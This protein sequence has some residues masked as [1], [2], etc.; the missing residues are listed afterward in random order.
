MDIPV[1]ETGR[2]A[3]SAAR[4]LA[5]LDTE[6]KNRALEIMAKAII[7]SSSFIQGE[8]GKDLEAGRKNGLT[9]AML[10]RLRLDAKGVEGMA[11]GIRD[12]IALP[13]PVGRVYDEIVRP[14]G[15]KVHK[16]RIPIGVFGIIYESRPNVTADASALCIKSGNAVILRGGSEAFNSNL[17]IVKVLSDSLSKAGITSDA[18]QFI[19]TTDREAV[20]SML[21]L[22]RYIDVIIP[23]GGPGLIK[24]VSE[25]S[26]IPVVKHDAGVCSVYVD[27]GAPFETA[28]DI[29]IN[30][31]TQRP[32]VCNAAEKLIVHSAW[33]ANLPKLLDALAEKGVEIRGDSRVCE[34][35]AKAKPA[36]E[37]DWT[38]EYLSLVISAKMVDS[39]EEAVDHIEEYGSHH[40]DSIVTPSKERGEKFVRAVDSSAVMVN[41]STRFNDGGEFGLGAEMGI[42]TQKLH[43]RGPMGLEELTTYKYVA[44]GEGHVRR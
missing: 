3:R 16:V 37:K 27:E 34:L 36:T 9:D 41:A 2:R 39:M 5:L 29:V 44:V 12:I 14:N 8:N 6:E 40:T 26:T 21:K 31:K 17:A 13:D 19:A 43:V 18:I 24:F 10:D 30:S 38:E 25:N 4:A 20:L 15:L 28:R 1:E 32:G 23:R 22:N 7:E 35:Y 42:S 11:K 33:R